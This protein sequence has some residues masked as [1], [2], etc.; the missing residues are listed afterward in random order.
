MIRFYAS[1]H[2]GNKYL[3]L[4]IKRNFFNIYEFISKSLFEEL[5]NHKEINHLL[6]DIDDRFVI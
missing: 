4:P 3:L 6:L 5:G 1:E 2:Q